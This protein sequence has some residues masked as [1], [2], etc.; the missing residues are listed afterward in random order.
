MIR[1][2]P[3]VLLL[4]ESSRAYGRN[5]LMG[6][7]SY[8]RAHGH[9]HVLHLER[10]LQEDVPATV[11]RQ[12]FDGVIARIENAKIAQSV[13][14][15]GVPTVDLRGLFHPRRGVCFN[16]DPNACA[17][18]AVEHFRQRGFRH[19]A[20]CGYEE[21]D[22][23]DQRRDAFLNCC[24]ELGMI[25]NVLSSQRKPKQS[26]GEHHV[27]TLGREAQGESDE[28]E[29][30]QWL[31]TL[32]K[33]V[34]VFACN[35]MRG[36]QVLGAA[37]RANFRVP[38]QVAVL[39]VD[40]DEVICDLSNPPLSS[41]EPDAHRIGFEGASLLARLMS[42]EILQSTHYLIP[43]SRVTV[44]RSTDVLAVDDRNLAEAIQFIRT[45]ACEGIGVTDVIEATAISRATLERRFRDSLGRSPR[46][47]IE[48]VRMDRVRMLLAETKYGLEQVA[49]L[50]G[51]RTAAH[52]V[53]AFRRH[54]GCTPG[55]YRK[56][57]R[58][59]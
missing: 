55:Q 30:A 25:P 31:A 42:G 54:E 1:K 5:C 17:A 7:A 33:P 52:L 39:G 59:R 12:R 13:E 48:R 3:Q 29:I 36:R 22:F 10:G 16:T 34:G 51:Y 4:I 50:T 19:L 8:M 57:F 35:D 28:K 44:R 47:E 26:V 43:P 58:D 24:V 6:I 46:E 49:S 27:D 41:I 56:P 23:S 15:F 32:P 45:H 38:D 40:D 18:I 21:V 20:Y 37:S 11:E 14:R 9:W 2:M 53:T